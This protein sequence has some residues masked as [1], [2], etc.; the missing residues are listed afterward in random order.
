[1]RFICTHT[2][3]P[4]AV[5][6]DQAKE[7]SKASQSDSTVRGYRSFMNLSEGKVVCI[8]EASD[9]NAVTNWFK[10]MN[11]PYDSVIALEYEGERGT[12]RE[13]AGVPAAV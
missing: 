11:L 4:H 10:K 3:P 2:L 13:E 1:M 8:M 9:K 5:T 12:I 6:C 7:I